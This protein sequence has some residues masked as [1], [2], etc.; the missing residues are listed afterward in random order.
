MHGLTFVNKKLNIAS[1]SIVMLFIGITF[2][3]VFAFTKLGIDL[4]PNVNLPHLMIQTSYPNSNPVAIEKLVT[5]LL[6]F[7]IGTVTGVKKISSVS[8]EG[9][10]IRSV[11]F[12]LGTDMDLSLLSQRKNWII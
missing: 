1:F 5:E 9:L 3:G 6:E 4:L 10:S 11:D 8:K 2:L 12:L 7:T